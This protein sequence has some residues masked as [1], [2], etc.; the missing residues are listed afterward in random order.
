VFGRGGSGLTVGPK[1]Y[2]FSGLLKC[3]VCG[4]RIALVSGRGRHGADRY[5]CSVHHPCG[6]S[7][8]E[9]AAWVRRDELEQGLLKGLADSVLRVEVIDYA[10]ARMEEALRKGHE[11]LNAEL[12]RQRKLQLEVSLRA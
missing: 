3:S 11:K 5:G 6:D 10:V 2:L 9:N 4:G 12:A 8:C 1:R 7:V